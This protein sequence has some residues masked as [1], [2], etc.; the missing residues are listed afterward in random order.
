MLRRDFIKRSVTALGMAAVGNYR[1][2]LPT[3]AHADTPDN[4][5]TGKLFIPPSL[6]T[7]GGH[8]RVE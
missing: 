4:P 1:N 8:W 2:Y 5:F 6:N 3:S 7:Y